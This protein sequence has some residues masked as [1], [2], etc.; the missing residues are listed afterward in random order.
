MGFFNKSKAD[1]KLRKQWHR[2][3]DDARQQDT[4]A[5][6]AEH[7]RHMLM[8]RIEKERAEYE[9][10][11]LEVKQQMT[12]NAAYNPNNLGGQT[13]QFG[14]AGQIYDSSHQHGIGQAPHFGVGMS[15]S[16]L[17]G[18]WVDTSGLATQIIPTGSYTP[19]GVTNQPLYTK[20]QWKKKYQA[21]QAALAA[22]LA[23]ANSIRNAH[24]GRYTG[25]QQLNVQ[26]PLPPKPF[27][28]DPPF[29]L[30]ELESAA[31]FIQELEGA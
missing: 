16:S 13:G 4:Q 29:S 19:L 5:K 8:D 26:E 1:I 9:R 31:T 25:F 17:S 22:Q 3:M 30:D 27:A 20:D 14:A 11:Q 24:C 7:K 12:M 23:Q 6:I 2:D 15:N 18:Q 28:F 21:Q 10:R